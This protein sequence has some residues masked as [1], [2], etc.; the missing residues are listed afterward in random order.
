MARTSTSESSPETAPQAPS[1]TQTDT[2]PAG[3]A[4]APSPSP[5]S[6]PRVIAPKPRVDGEHVM[7]GG[8]KYPMADAVALG[9]VPSGS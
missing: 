1:V 5:R 9:L 8:T 6:K 4:D 3:P 7:Y 2:L